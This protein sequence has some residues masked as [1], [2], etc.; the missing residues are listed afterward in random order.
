[1]HLDRVQLTDAGE[2]VLLAGELQRFLLVK[3]IGCT[4]MNLISTMTCKAEAST[5]D[6][7]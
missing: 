4:C 6:F 1:M 2:P 3:V 7:S 5:A